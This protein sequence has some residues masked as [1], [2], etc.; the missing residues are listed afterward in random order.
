M[1]KQIKKRNKKYNA[2]KG[3]VKSAKVGLKNLGVFMPC[4]QALKTASI[5]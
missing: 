2:M 4:K 3:A 1:A 5:T